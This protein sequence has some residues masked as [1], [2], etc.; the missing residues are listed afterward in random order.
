MNAKNLTLPSSEKLGLLSNLST[1]INAG[2]TM[3]EAV[4]SLQ[5]YYSDRRDP[6]VCMVPDTIL[7]DLD[8]VNEKEFDALVSKYLLPVPVKSTVQ[9]ILL[10]DND[11]CFSTKLEAGKEE[12]IKKNHLDDSPFLHVVSTSFTVE[13]TSL[14]IT[15]NQDL[16]QSVGRVLESHRYVILAVCPWQ[17]V[18]YA[19]VVAQG[20]VFNATSIKRLFD[21]AESIKQLGFLYEK[22]SPV[23]SIVDTQKKPSPKKLS[24]GLI[25]FIGIAVVYLIGM[26]VWL[27][28]RK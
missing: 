20:E 25:V 9:T 22:Q 28:L 4:D 23:T 15:A 27:I 17:I 1:M 18:Q 13:G 5:I 19:K 24:K 11:I 3:A 21:G 8:I 7:K 12:E 26:L 6:V 16:I 14:F 2:L 10:L